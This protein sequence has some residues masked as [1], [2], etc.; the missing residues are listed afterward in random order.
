MES[1]KRSILKTMAF[2][3]AVIGFMSVGETMTATAQDYINQTDSTKSDKQKIIVTWSEIN[4]TDDGQ[5]ISVNSEDFWKIFGPLLEL[6]NNKTID[7]FE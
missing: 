1:K 4:K 3:I 5:L 6:S 2:I 7:T